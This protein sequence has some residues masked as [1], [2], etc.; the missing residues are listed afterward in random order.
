MDGGGGVVSGRP[1]LTAV[2]SFS[3]AVSDV[4][5]G[6]GWA[7]RSIAL[8]ASNRSR[9]LGDSSRFSWDRYSRPLELSLRCNEESQQFTHLQGKLID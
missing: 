8:S 4:V 1:C 7:E 2:S 3:G 6:C 9:L 5:C